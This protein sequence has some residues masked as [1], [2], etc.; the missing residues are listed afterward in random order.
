MARILKIDNFTKTSPSFYGLEGDGS[1]YM[2][3]KPFSLD[4]LVSYNTK[5][6]I[7]DVNYLE[8]TWASFDCSK[9]DLITCNKNGCYIEPQK[10]E[11]FVEC[12]PNKKT[13]PGEPSFDRFPKENLKKEGKDLINS[14]PMDFAERKKITI[15]S[16]I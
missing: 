15:I 7:G 3:T 11:S 4:I 10:S 9:G 8:P 12:R 5:G 2:V 6:K 16:G 14:S 1:C 13:K